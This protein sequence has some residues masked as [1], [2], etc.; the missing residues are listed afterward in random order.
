MRSRYRRNPGGLHVAIALLHNHNSACGDNG[1]HTSFNNH[2]D[3][4]FNYGPNDCDA[5]AYWWRV[6]FANKKHQL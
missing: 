6:L 1:I 5:D 3:N 4:W 2:H